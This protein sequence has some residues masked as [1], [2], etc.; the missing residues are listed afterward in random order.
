M[1]LMEEV[2]IVP[3][4]RILDFVLAYC[5]GIVHLVIAL[6]LF[7]AAVLDAAAKEYGYIIY[8][9][10][11]VYS[12]ALYALYKHYPRLMM[13]VFSVLSICSAAL[14]LVVIC[15]FITLFSMSVVLQ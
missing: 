8:V 2:F 6:S 15:T 1:E 7:L 13:V 9:H 11:I 5:I 10:L 4:L 3:F 14:W 12:Y